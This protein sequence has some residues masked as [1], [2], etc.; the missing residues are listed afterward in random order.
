MRELACRLFGLS[1]TF[2]FGNRL[3]SYYTIGDIQNAKLVVCL[4][5]QF[6]KKT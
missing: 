5:S 2:N 4:Y 3:P 6:N 1:F